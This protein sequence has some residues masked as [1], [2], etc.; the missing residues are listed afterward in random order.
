M[1]GNLEIMETLIVD[2]V[3]NHGYDGTKGDWAYSWD[4]TNALLFTVTI[5]TTIGYGHIA[6]K[7]IEGQMFTILYA[8]IGTPLLLVFLANI[9]DGMGKVFT[10]TYRSEPVDVDLSDSW[11]FT[12]IFGYIRVLQFPSLTVIY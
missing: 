5:M 11:I 6:P 8:M 1:K 3:N 12:T 7:T 9:G 4:F 10:Y 2:M